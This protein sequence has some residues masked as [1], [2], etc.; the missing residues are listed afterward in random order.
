MSISQPER[1][2]QRYGVEPTCFPVSKEAAEAVFSFLAKPKD[3]L[4]AHRQV[5]QDLIDQNHHVLGVLIGIAEAWLLAGEKEIGFTGG[6]VIGYRALQEQAALNG[7]SIPAVSAETA[8]TYETDLNQDGN[9]TADSYFLRRRDELEF[10]DPYYFEAL[11]L[12]LQVTA[13]VGRGDQG[14]MT[15]MAGVMIYDIIKKQAYAD[16]M[17]RFFEAPEA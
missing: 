9:S 12:P 2:E 10:E 14:Y 16:E 4:D 5:I 15:C 1:P 13:E 17:L 6:I 8:A 7:A 3:H 11:R